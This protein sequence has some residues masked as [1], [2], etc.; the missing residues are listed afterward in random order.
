M[1]PLTELQDLKR[2]AYTL[3]KLNKIARTVRKINEND[4]NYQISKAQETR[5]DNLEKEA[6]QIACHDL[7]LTIYCQRDPRGCALYLI[8]SEEVSSGNYSN[9]LAL[10]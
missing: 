1:L 3:Q 2:A 9:G 5:R 8:D 10:Y 6:T 7:G 4:C